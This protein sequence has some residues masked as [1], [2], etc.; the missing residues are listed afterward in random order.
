MRELDFYTN[1]GPSLHPDL[2][3]YFTP[4]YFGTLTLQG[5]MGDE[6]QVEAVDNEGEQVG[7]SASEQ[8][9]Q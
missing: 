3:G 6:G 1:V 2:I 7:L 4:A 5:K 8:M 9:K